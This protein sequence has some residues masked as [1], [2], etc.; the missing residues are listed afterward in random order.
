MT[1]HIIET[2]DVQALRPGGPGAVPTP[3]MDT[4]TVR[5][6][7]LSLAAGQSVAP[8][9][10]FAT[11]LYFVIAGK[12]HLRV[13]GEQA[14]LPV[15]PEGADVHHEELGR[16]RGRARGRAVAASGDGRLRR[17]NRWS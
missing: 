17:P 4:D 11:V 10:M 12:G 7:L 5:A 13:E 6:L 2:K 9:Q 3:L 1:I 16:G 8:C 14:E 15:A